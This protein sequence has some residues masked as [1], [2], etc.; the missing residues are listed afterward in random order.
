M[1]LHDD[2]DLK[3]AV[4][5]ESSWVHSTTKIYT[6]LLLQVVGNSIDIKTTMDPW[7]YQMR[8][9]VVNIT[10]LGNGSLSVSQ[11]RFLTNPASNVSDPPSEFG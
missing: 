10:D 7:L 9:P 8:L 3:N 1:I 2:Q 5:L 11:S 6:L 4:P